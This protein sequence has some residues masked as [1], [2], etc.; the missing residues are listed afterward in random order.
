MASCKDCIHSILCPVYAPNFDDVLAQGDKC[1]SYINK[2]DVVE[3][4]HGKWTPMMSVCNRGMCSV[5]NE[6]GAIRWNYCPNCGAKMDG[7][8]ETNA[9]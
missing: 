7:R 9:E 3:V 5:C 6:V 1:A 2:A 4:K 8:S